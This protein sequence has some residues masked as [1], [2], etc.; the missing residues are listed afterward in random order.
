MSEKLFLG[1]EEVKG[2]SLYEPFPLN[3]MEKG[4]SVCVYFKETR[5]ARS[6]E[7]GEFTVMNGVKFDCKASTLDELK[8]SMALKSMPLNVMLLNKIAAGAMRPGLFYRLEKAWNKGDK[9][10]NSKNKRARGHGYNVFKLQA[11]ENLIKVFEEFIA[12]KFGVSPAALK[13]EAVADTK[14]QTKNPRPRI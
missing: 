5:E 4:Q 1:E 3:E 2:S 11:P 10:P 12:E 6:T 7:F 13:E 9:V 14:E 8:N